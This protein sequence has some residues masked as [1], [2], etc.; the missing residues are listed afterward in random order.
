MITKLNYSSPSS[1]SGKILPTKG[2]NQVSIEY[3]FLIMLVS[4]HSSSIVASQGLLNLI[5]CFPLYQEIGGSKT[6][7][8]LPVTKFI[9]SVGYDAKEQIY[10]VQNFY[11]FKTY[12]RIRLNCIFNLL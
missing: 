12:W 11:A 6:P 5:R 2:E 1:Y 3:T 4:S 10:S 8:K 7:Q 9:N